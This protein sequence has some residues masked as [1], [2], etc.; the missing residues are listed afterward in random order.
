MANKKLVWVLI[1]LSLFLGV[2]LTIKL[3]SPRVVE[4]FNILHGEANIQNA[5]F[6]A[7]KLKE[8]QVHL[9]NEEIEKAR[10]LFSILLLAL[11]WL[12]LFVVLTR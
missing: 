11:S 10:E 4:T 8:I 6:R 7:N 12:L 9:D 1:P 2:F 3:V 5:K